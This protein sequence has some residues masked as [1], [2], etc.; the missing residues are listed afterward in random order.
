[1]A[2]GDAKLRA[3]PWAHPWARLGVAAALAV[4]SGAPALAASAGFDVRMVVPAAC[5]VTT[6]SPI[7]VT[8]GGPAT[9][10]AEEACNSGGYTI[11]AHYRALQAD[12]SVT[13][14]YG[15]QSISLPAQGDAVV[16]VSS[17]A[18]IKQVAYT[19]QSQH[20]DAPLCVSLSVTPG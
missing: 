12:E 3:H 18:D 4:A 11:R 20:L 15:G 19:V 13:I 6:T 5:S 9:G 7:E 8:D 2:R 10:S 14:Q 17:I 1:M 16:H